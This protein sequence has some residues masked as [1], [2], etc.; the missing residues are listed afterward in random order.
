MGKFKIENFNK[1]SHKWLSENIYRAGVRKKDGVVGVEDMVGVEVEEGTVGGVG[2]TKR[3]MMTMVA[4]VS[5]TLVFFAI[6]W[7]NMCTCKEY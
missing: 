2:V 4:G 3:M 7:T 6:F 5:R 1:V